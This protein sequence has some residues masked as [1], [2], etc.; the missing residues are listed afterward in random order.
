VD[1]LAILS[2]LR[3]DKRY[4]LWGLLPA[5]LT[6]E[7]GFAYPS[8]PPPRSVQNVIV[9]G[10]L[11]ML[12]ANWPTQPAQSTEEWKPYLRGNGQVRLE[13]SKEMECLALWQS[14]PFNRSCKNRSIM[15]LRW[16]TV[17]ILEG[18]VQPRR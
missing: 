3:P 14:H 8:P 12:F 4:H 9:S 15:C 18:A 2:I 10:L 7:T 1:Y 17:P 5:L 16:A 11:W 6:L 13:T